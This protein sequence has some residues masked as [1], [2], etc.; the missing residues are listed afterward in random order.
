MVKHDQ[1][2]DTSSLKESVSGSLKQLTTH[3][4]DEESY[5][6]IIRQLN[7]MGVDYLTPEQVNKSIAGLTFEK[8]DNKRT[9]NG[10]VRFLFYLVNLPMVV[11][12]RMLVKPKVPEPEFMATFRFGFALFSYPMLQRSD[13]GLIIKL[14]LL[15]EPKIGQVKTY[16]E[17]FM[18]HS[19]Y[20][21][22]SYNFKMQFQ[23]ANSIDTN[24]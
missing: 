16:K 2:R 4:H 8:Q 22:E 6:T 23:T 13:Q 14:L 11:L 20:L 3:V 12:W 24:Q 18:L 9:K 5:D 21:Y 1:H 7:Y 15:F 19:R 10:L 17:K